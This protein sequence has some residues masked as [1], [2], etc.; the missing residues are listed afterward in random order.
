[1]SLCIL[2]SGAMYAS[3]RDI[4]DRVYEKIP[5]YAEALGLR[6]FTARGHHYRDRIPPEYW[7]KIIADAEDRGVGGVDMETLNRLMPSRRQPEPAEAA[8]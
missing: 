5:A 3:H 8:E 4:L 7:P 2:Y 1:M 6:Y